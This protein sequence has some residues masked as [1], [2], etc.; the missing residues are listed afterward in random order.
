MQL[1]FRG[2]RPP[3]AARGKSICIPGVSATVPASLQ[4]YPAVPP[5]PQWYPPAHP[6]QHPGNHSS[7]K[8]TPKIFTDKDKGNNSVALPRSHGEELQILPIYLCI[9]NVQGCVHLPTYIYLF[10]IPPASILLVYSPFRPFFWDYYNSFFKKHPM[11]KYFFVNVFLSPACWNFKEH[12][13]MK[14]DRKFWPFCD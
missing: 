7:Y 11:C 6:C 5:S 10:P 4:L 12:F 13:N 1:M 2:L 14:L 9:N 3:L 8:K